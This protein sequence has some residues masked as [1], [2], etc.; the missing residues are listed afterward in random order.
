MLVGYYRP[1][2]TNSKSPYSLDSSPLSAIVSSMSSTHHAHAYLRTSPSIGKKPAVKGSRFTLAAKTAVS[3]RFAV[4][5]NKSKI[6]LEKESGRG[7]AINEIDEGDA[8]FG[9]GDQEEMGT[10]FLQYWY[11][12]YLLRPKMG[13]G[14]L[15]LTMIVISAMCEKQIVVPNNSILYCSER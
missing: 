7:Q 8:S 6:K 1:V 15:L 9:E 11:I 3:N 4:K 10:T 12:H 14:F 13:D 5:G 2:G